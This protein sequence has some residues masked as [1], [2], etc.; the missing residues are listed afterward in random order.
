MPHSRLAQVRLRYGA[1]C[2]YCGVSEVDAGGELTVDHHRPVAAGGGE[3]DDNL[4]YACVRCNLYKGDFFPG[5]I[6]VTCGWRVLH[7]LHDDMS[8]H[9]G[10]DAR[11]GLLVPLTETG[12]FHIALLHLN[13]PALVQHR[14]RRQH[15]R[16]LEAKQRL[17]KLENARLRQTVQAQ[18]TWIEE[19]HRLLGIPY[20]RDRNPPD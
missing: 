5:P 15:A 7:P 16:L 12:R 3:D 1:C 4:V 10:E 6:H 11:T 20:D 2:G 17:L 8:L 18:E 13:R 14:L 9:V 19:L